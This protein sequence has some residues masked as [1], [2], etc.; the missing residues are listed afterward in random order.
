[1]RKFARMQRMGLFVIVAL[2]IFWSSG[3]SDRLGK[4]SL[5]EARERLFSGRDPRVGLWKSENPQ[6][7]VKGN[8]A[9]WQAAYCMWLNHTQDFEQEDVQ[10]CYSMLVDREGI[11]KTNCERNLYFK[12]EICKTLVIDNFFQGSLDACLRSDDSV[13]LVVRE[14]I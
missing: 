14:G 11:P 5:P 8:A 7:E 12:R 2:A 3:C 13:P 6:C 9:N 10:D 1:M 4:Q